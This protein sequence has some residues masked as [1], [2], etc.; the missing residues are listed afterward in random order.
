MP[1][2][3][4]TSESEF[5][6]IDVR[7]VRSMSTES[8]KIQL[9]GAVAAKTGIQSTHAEII[10]RHL[11]DLPNSPIERR[12][13]VLELG[14]VVLS[15]HPTTVRQTGFA[16][17]KGPS[18]QAIA[19]FKLGNKPKKLTFREFQIAKLDPEKYFKWG[20]VEQLITFGG[21][22]GNDDVPIRIPK[23]KR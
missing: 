8:F 19:K 9:A 18:Y 12:L 2:L 3:A 11:I 15:N 22:E 5:D 13:N 21:L 17:K 16:G 7:A 6:A 1:D 23:P 10:L 14:E 4:L 20:Q